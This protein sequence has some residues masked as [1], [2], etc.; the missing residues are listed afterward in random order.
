MKISKKIKSLLDVY[1]QKGVKIDLGCG[2]FKTQG[3]IGIDKRNVKGVD[4]V[5]DL[6]MIPYP[7]PNECASLLIASHVIQQIKPWLFVDV[8]NEWW[9]ILKIGGELMI[10]TPYAGSFGFYQDPANIKGFN[11]AW[12]A[13]FDPLENIYSHGELYKVYRPKP[14]KIKIHTFNAER[15]EFMN[16]MGNLEV[17]LEKRREDSSYY[18]S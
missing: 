10:S 8:M 4:I 17:V 12:I 7:L 9:R 6:E 16:T 15:R 14:W 5:H 18:K 13:Y 2:E 11:E 3:T 1:G